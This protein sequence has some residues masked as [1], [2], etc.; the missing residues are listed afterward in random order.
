MY[1]EH[2][3]DDR[4]LRKFYDSKLRIDYIYRANL[5]KKAVK[6]KEVNK[7]VGILERDEYFLDDEEY[8]RRV[9]SD[10]RWTPMISKFLDLHKSVQYK[11]AL[12]ADDWRPLVSEQINAKKIIFTLEDAWVAF[13]IKGDNKLYLLE[14]KD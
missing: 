12:L 13:D 1:K 9:N 14:W 10:Q 4:D 2:V 11:T 8:E 5:I 7:I 6:H 3:T